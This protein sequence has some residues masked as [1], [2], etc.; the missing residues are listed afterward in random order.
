LKRREK[1]SSTKKQ[2]GGP[3]NHKRREKEK[4]KKFLDLRPPNMIVIISHHNSK[5]GCDNGNF[6]QKGEKAVLK[7]RK[8]KSRKVRLSMIPPWRAQKF[9]FVTI[10][11]GWG[12]KKFTI[13]GGGQ[14]P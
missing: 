13:H 6:R 1:N 10:G 9:Q 5:D 14:G 4:K 2:G 8:K 3:F 11:G 7:K 12:E